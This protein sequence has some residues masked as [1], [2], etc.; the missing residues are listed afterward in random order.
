MKKGFLISYS[1]DLRERVVAAIEA[2]HTRVKVADLYNMA[3]STVSGISKRKRGTGRC[4]FA[5]ACLPDRCRSL[6]ASGSIAATG[7]AGAHGLS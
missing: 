6:S 4:Q 2:G 5:Q 3:L 1:D 7:L